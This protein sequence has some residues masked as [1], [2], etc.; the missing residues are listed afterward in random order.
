VEK[1][2]KYGKEERKI[3]TLGEPFANT[4]KKSVKFGK[5]ARK[6]IALGALRPAA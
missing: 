4:W 6:I 3:I 5:E 1:K 2:G